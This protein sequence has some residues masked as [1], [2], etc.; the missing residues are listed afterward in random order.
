MS[1]NP[2]LVHIEKIIKPRPP[3]QPRRA[4]RIFLEWH[5]TESVVGSSFTQQD[6]ANVI[7]IVVNAIEHDPL[8]EPTKDNNVEGDVGLKQNNFNDSEIV[9]QESGDN[10]G[11]NEGSD[12]DDNVV[13]NDEIQGEDNNSI[14]DKENLIGD[15]D[16]NMDDFVENIGFK[17]EW[18]RGTTQ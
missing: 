2:L 3:S 4:R 9:R 12:R 15:V 1:P 18:I 16:V 8:L 11:S 14:V 17:D 6:K 5:D 10:L 13:T 7:E